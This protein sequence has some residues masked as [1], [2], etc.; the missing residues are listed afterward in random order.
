[1]E[2][3][4]NFRERA[5]R[6][7]RSVSGREFS[8]GPLRDRVELL[9]SALS[10]ASKQN[11][12]SSK[13][14]LENYAHAKQHEDPIKV[15]STSSNFILSLLAD[16]CKFGTKESLGIDAMNALIQGLRHVYSENGHTQAWSISTDGIATGNP[17]INNPDVDSLRKAHRVHLAR[18]GSVPLKARPITVG[19]V[20]DHAEKFWFGSNYGKMIDIRDIQLHA[21]FLLGLNLGLRYDEISK[22]Q[23]QR[24][25]VNSEGI[26]ITLVEAIKNSTVQRDYR[27][28][29]WEGDESLRSSIYMDPNTALL[30]WLNVRGSNHGPLF[31]D[32]SLSNAGVTLNPTKRLSSKKFI[33]WMRDRLKLIGIGDED[34]KMYSGH[35]LKRGAVQLYRSLGYRDEMIMQIIQMTGHHAYANYCAAYNDCAPQELPRFTSV[36]EYI[37]HAKTL[38]KESQ[39]VSNEDSFEEW[40]NEIGRNELKEREE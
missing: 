14:I 26:V 39:F 31:C 9:T 3:S 7:A 16:Y 37:G 15:C 10:E 30:S 13:K 36:Q 1:M 24:V 20:C 22:L 19:I 23:L 25:S 11:I 12:R 4:E 35:S 34:A 8:S 32:Y 2:S 27:L 40:I 38:M 17:L 33:D 28:R 5:G 18:Y 6:G 29:D 21:I